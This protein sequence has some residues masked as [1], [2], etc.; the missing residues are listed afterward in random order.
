MNSKKNFFRTAVAK[1]YPN[2]WKPSGAKPGPSQKA[3]QRE[4]NHGK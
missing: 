3:D 2:N 4:D 1:Q